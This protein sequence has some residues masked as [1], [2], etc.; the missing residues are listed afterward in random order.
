MVEV[1]GAD[2][3]LHAHGADELAVRRIDD[4]AILFAVADPHIAILG[5]DRKAMGGIELAL[6]HFIA[7]PLADILAVLGQV[8]HAGHAFL[9]PGVRAV[10]VIGAL[11][12]MAAGDID[13]AIGPKRHHHRLPEQALALVLDPVAA[14]A[15]GAE[16]QQQLAFGR[17]LHHRRLA[18]VGDP[19]IVFLVHRHAMGLVLV[20]DHVLAHL[21]HQLLV[22]VELHQLHHAGRAALEDPQIALGIQRH[23]GDA[24]NALGH[25]I[26]I[27]E[28]VAQ[29]LVPLDAGQLAALKAALAAADGGMA[30]GRAG[31]AAGHAPGIAGQRG[32]F[33]AR[34]HMH[35]AVILHQGEAGG[36]G[37]TGAQLPADIAVLR[38]LGL[39]RQAIGL[40]QSGGGEQ[41][42]RQRG[43][44][45]GLHGK[46]P[47]IKS[48][49]VGRTMRGQSGRRQ[50]STRCV[51]CTIGGNFR[52]GFTVR[53]R[54]RPSRNGRIQSPAPRCSRPACIRQ[55]FARPARHAAAPQLAAPAPCLCHCPAHRYRD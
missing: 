27:A 24:A 29:V 3:V 36:I 39:D 21:K 6:A 4:D 53:I 20:A 30:A 1:Q 34:D 44:C 10:H 49:F 28:L 37:K 31:I 42:E 41:A 43:Q 5:I 15:L 35:A 54:P 19:D 8:Q 38:R 47:L 16:R 2:Q 40:R 46:R 55:G 22:G 48:H 51:R 14:L 45:H 13:I 23:R 33:L 52:S 25:R 17:Q 12:G 32:A 26:G 11:I 18:I 7:E 9:V 50:P